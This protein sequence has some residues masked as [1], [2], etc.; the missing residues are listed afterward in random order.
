MRNA[1]LPAVDFADEKVYI[2]FIAGSSGSGYR[3]E[4]ILHN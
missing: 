1:S 3:I 2:V 4:Q